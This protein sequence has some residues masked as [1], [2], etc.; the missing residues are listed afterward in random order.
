VSEHPEEVS[1]NL[2]VTVPGATGVIIP[3]LATVAIVVANEDHVPPVVGESK[4]VLP[5]HTEAGDVKTGCDLTVRFEVVFEH[6]VVVLVKVNVTVPAAT[7]VT[8]PGFVT[9]ASAWSLLDQVPPV[10]GVILIVEFT[11]TNEAADKVG[12][13]TIVTAGVVVLQ[14]V[15]LSTQINVTLPAETPVITPPLVTFALLTLLLVHVTP[16][17]GVN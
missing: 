1:K 4:P 6:P 12:F 2:K 5:I 16:V 13:A 3:V 8:T 14:V 9:V 17:V 15:V 11:Q 7:P 10:A